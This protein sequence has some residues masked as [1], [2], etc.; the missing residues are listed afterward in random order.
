MLAAWFF[1]MTIGLRRGTR[2]SSPLSMIRSLGI[3]SCSRFLALVAFSAANRCTLRRK[4]LWW[5]SRPGSSGRA[6]DHAGRALPRHQVDEDHFAAIRF[7][8][9]VPDH[10]VAGIVAALDQYSRAHLADQF[11]RRVLPED[12]DE[13]GRLQPTEH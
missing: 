5:P 6:R 9:V 1:V 10:L 8:S 4:M 12:H 3:G 13:I 2:A 11:R 7:D